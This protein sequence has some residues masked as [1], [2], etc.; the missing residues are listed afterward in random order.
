MAGDFVGYCSSCGQKVGPFLDPG[1]TIYFCQECRAYCSV[2]YTPRTFALPD[3][4]HCGQ[5][6]Q[7]EDLVLDEP[8]FCPSCLS[9]SVEWLAS[10]VV[11]LA[12]VPEPQPEV[13]DLVQGFLRNT[14]NGQRVDFIHSVLCGR[15]RDAAPD[16]PVGSPVEARV[17]SVD[18]DVVDVTFVR[19]L[20]HL[21]PSQWEDDDW[22]DED[23]NELFD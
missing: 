7:G 10:A 15:L 16:V 17:V 21:P 6:V 19:W 4:P 2:Q 22:D 20:D 8:T 11:S 9:D 5:Q 14:K 1:S 23:L 13:G 18:E 12:Y 3:C